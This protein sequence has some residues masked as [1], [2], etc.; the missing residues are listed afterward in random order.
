MIKQII[1]EIK[2]QMYIEHPNV[3]KL[4]TFFHDKSSLYLLLELFT[5]GHLYDLLQ[6]RFFIE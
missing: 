6:K 5:S 4:Y 3:V 2:I 1:H